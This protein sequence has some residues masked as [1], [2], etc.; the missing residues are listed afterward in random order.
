MEEGVGCVPEL[1][2]EEDTVG[3]SA[4]VIVADPVEEVVADEDLLVADADCGES[5]AEP[6][7][8]SVALRDGDSVSAGVIVEDCVAL[9]VPRLVDD[10]IELES[11][12]RDDDE[13]PVP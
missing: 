5:D 3:V 4:G 11:P 12:V 2:W 6:E 13:V 7:E 9:P 8:V 1:L 10:D